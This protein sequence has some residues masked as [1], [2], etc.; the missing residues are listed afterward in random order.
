[1][2]EEVREAFIIHNPLNTLPSLIIF[3]DK[4]SNIIKLIGA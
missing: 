3:E 4:Q 2:I 1:M